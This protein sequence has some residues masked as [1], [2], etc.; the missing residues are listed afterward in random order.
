MKIFKKPLLIWIVKKKSG[1]EVHEKIN[2][3]AGITRTSEALRVP[4][5]PKDFRDEP[6]G[7][8][9]HLLN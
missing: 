6:Q 4:G 9:P 3:R 2:A 1:L 7:S 8:N 5:N